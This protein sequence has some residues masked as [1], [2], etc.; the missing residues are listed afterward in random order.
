MSFNKPYTPAKPGTGFRPSGGGSRSRLIK[1]KMPV[2]ENEHRLNEEIRVPRVRLV[3]ENGGQVGVVDTREAI[4]MARDKGLDLMEVAANASPPVCKIC[5]YGKFKYEKK[6]KDSV[7]KKKQVA[8]KVKEVQLRPNTEEHDLE[9]KFR[10]IRSFLEDGDKAKI[11]VLFR[12]REAAY[13]Q[14][15]LGTLHDLAKKMEDI[16]VIE[17]PPKM[18]GRKMM[19]ILA[20]KK[21]GASGKVDNS[22]PIVAGKLKIG[23]KS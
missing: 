23:S 8:I 3:D 9:Y 17:S 20:P 7:A 13:S 2:M 19:M 6:K 12:G 16:S 18:E 15:S 11:T 4:R 1:G 5:D 10:N 14:Q 22:P 21:A